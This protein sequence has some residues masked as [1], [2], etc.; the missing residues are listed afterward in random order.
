MNEWGEMWWDGEKNEAK[1]EDRHHHEGRST[2]IDAV[3]EKNGYVL[4]GM[5]VISDVYFVTQNNF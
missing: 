5:Y 4:Y 2:K 1:N 3:K